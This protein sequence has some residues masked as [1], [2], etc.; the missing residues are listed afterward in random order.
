MRIALIDDEEAWRTIIYQKIKKYFTEADIRIFQS[1]SEFIQKQETFD[2]VFLDIEM[3]GMDGF[4]TAREYR[5][6]APDCIIIILTTHS[7]MVK[8]GYQVNAFRYLDKINLDEELSEAAAAVRKRFQK[9]GKI[10]VPL[11]G[12]GKKI[13]E[14]KDILYVETEKR[15]ICIH[16]WNES[17]ISSLEIGEIEEMMGESFFRCHRSYIVNLDMVKEVNRLDLI[18]KNGDTVLLSARK[19]ADFKQRYLNWRYEYANA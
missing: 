13:F 4:E 16:T 5:E 1:G 7:E 15:N 19:R 11:V 2:I 18:L 6:Y 12:L 9:S 14:L 10:T 3:A 17:F 8:R